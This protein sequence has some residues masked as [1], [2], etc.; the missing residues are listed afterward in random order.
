[1][2]DQLVVAGD[3]VRLACNDAMEDGVR[4]E[5]NRLGGGTVEYLSFPTGVN[6]KFKDRMFVVSDHPGQ[7]DL[8]INRTQLDDAG[9][10]RCMSAVDESNTRGTVELAFLGMLLM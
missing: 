3:S 10:Y 8:L 2:S 5:R 1:M 9:V 4:W 7:Y 6:V